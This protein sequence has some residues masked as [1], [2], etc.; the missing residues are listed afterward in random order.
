MTLLETLHKADGLR[1][2]SGSGAFARLELKPAL[3]DVDLRAFEAALP[4]T[5]SDDVRAALGFARGFAGSGLVPE[6]D[7]V[8][9]DDYEFAE[10]FSCPIAIAED[11]YGNSWV[12]DITSSS[13]NFGPVFFVS[14]D[15]PVLVYQSESLERFV[16]ETLKMAG[17]PFSSGIDRVS[18]DDVVNIWDDGSDGARTVAACRA[19]GDRHLER[20]AAELDA[21]FEIVDLRNAREGDGFAWGRYGPD[22]HVCRFGEER[23]FAYQR[24]RTFLQRLL[25]T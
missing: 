8:G 23:I 10:L 11:G 20:F 5:L 12:A 25:R 21:T 3:S 17:P 18:N 13:T 2:D 7:F 15:P 14:H 6:I 9:V 19:S 24:P 16:R 1:T 22:A 4:T